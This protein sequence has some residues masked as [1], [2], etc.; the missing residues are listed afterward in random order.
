MKA[1]LGR[2]WLTGLAAALCISWTAPARADDDGV[3]DPLSQQ[4]EL[5]LWW[6]DF[7]TLEKLYLDAGRSKDVNEYNGRT[8][9][10]SVRGGL[11]E[12]LKY[13][14]LN[15]AYFREFELLTERWARE[16]P[17]SVLA[18]LLYA[19]V[20]YGRAWHIRGN[21]YWS[22][23][24]RG[25]KDEFV[26]LIAKAEAHI[27]DRSSLLLRDTSAH[28]YLMLIG[29]SAG[30]SYQQRYAL[31]QDALLKSFDDEEALYEDLVLS[32][33]PKWGGS[34]RDVQAF[35]D[36]MG[37]RTQARRGHEVYALLWTHVVADVEGNPFKVTSARWPLIKQGFESLAAKRAHPFFANRLAYFACQAEDRDTA[38][39]WMSRLDNKPGIQ[40]WRGG[41]AGG[42]Q[43]LEDCQRWLKSNR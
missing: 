24:P 31:L 34:W 38:S 43:N 14:H 10:Q 7:D 18:Q 16:Q 40:Y 3:K 41:G 42:R 27:A 23:V 29:R 2:G 1:S 19:R 32:L 9:R 5:A 39:Q 30:W 20:L 6:G 21:G 36:D 37:Q 26:R 35:I 15:D 22:G 13:D 8:A 17:Q 25:A 12:T 28:V 4:A 11:A 33:L